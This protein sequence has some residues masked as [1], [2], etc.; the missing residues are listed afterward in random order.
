MVAIQIG[1]LGH[2]VRNLVETGAIVVVVL[3]P[4]LLQ[5][6]GERI[7]QDSVRMNRKEIAI[8]ETVPVSSL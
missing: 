2:S 1:V 5:A 8:T 7:A 6:L 3:A 4:I